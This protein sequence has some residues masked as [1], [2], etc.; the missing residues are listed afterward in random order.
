MIWYLYLM[1][2]TAHFDIFDIESLPEA[3]MALCE[4]EKVLEAESS[5]GQP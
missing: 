4:S 2:F 5:V 1:Q 3:N